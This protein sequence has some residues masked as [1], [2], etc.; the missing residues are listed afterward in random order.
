MCTMWRESSVAFWSSARKMCWGREVFINSLEFSCEIIWGA[1]NQTV[2]YFVLKTAGKFSNKS[3]KERRRNCDETRI[4]YFSVL[5]RIAWV[6]RKICTGEKKKLFRHHPSLI[7]FSSIA[8]RSLL[9]ELPFTIHSFWISHSQFSQQSS[10]C[11][12]FYLM[13]VDGVWNHER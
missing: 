7:F 10:K 4:V 11:F 1:S 6:V 3:L 5:Q 9:S 12:I 2:R 8:L 13:V